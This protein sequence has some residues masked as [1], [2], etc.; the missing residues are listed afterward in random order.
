MILQA[1]TRLFE[2][3]TRQGKIARP[4]WT[5]SKIS[6]ALCLNEAGVLEYVIPLQKEIMNGQKIQLRPS[7]IVLPTP[8]IRSGTSARSN[9]LWDNSSYLLGID[10]K[11][12][13]ER[14]EACFQAC[15]QLHHSLLDSVASPVAKAILAFL[16]TW[17]PQTA[18]SHPALVDCLPE[19]MKGGNMIFRVNGTY[20]QED[21][22]I[23]SAWDSNY[24]DSQGERQQCLVTGNPDIPELVHPTIKGVI[25][26]QSSGAAIVSFNAPAFCSY[27]KEQSLNAPVGKYAA[28][29]YTAALNYLLSDNSNVH[30]IG[31][32]TIVCW[33]EGAEPQYS[34]FAALSI[35]GDTAQEGLRDQD[36]RDAMHLLAQ[37]LP[38]QELRL[39]PQRP[40]YILGLAPNAA[41]ISVR[42]FCRNS[43]GIIIKNVNAHHNRMEIVGNRYAITPLW[44][45][46]RET[47]NMN[48]TDKSPSPVM[49]GAVA[50]SI[51][52][53]TAYPA[54]LIES[55]ML[56][57]RAEREIT[58]GRAAIIKAFYL[59]NPNL[60]CPKEVL[61]VSLNESST[62]I[63]YTLGR[64]FAV[65]EEIQE[66][67]NPGINATIKDKYFNSASATPAT[68]FPILD[69]LCQK[70]LRKLEVGLKISYDRRISALKN[71]L[72]ESYPT[73]LGLP[74]Q[75]SFNLGYY[76]QKQFRYT[77]KEEK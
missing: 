50:R 5:P 29:A 4:G 48:T 8:V 10:E 34:L 46:L 11:G 66:R 59:N 55:V 61:T 60:L 63:P 27:G 67:A 30:R 2:D 62:N 52:L 22:A 1:L 38:C 15:R 51:F 44:A 53:G 3:L 71:I 74:E 72:S 33:A 58:P 28:F 49:A 26:A 45:M 56:R 43:F 21:P 41:R 54:S 31:D 77:K 25:G 20:G 14:S 36:L 47:V 39:D 76:H 35:F 24:S 73:R 17:D 23:C 64:L 18:R 13:P 68:I 75:G 70:H 65:Y 16:D 6:F 9:F 57:I 69:N 37:G 12:K 32:T 42:F 7:L 40:F 19:L